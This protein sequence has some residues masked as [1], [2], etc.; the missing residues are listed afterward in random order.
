MYVLAPPGAMVK[1]LPEQIVPL[2][3]VTK[4]SAIT[5]TFETATVGDMQPNELVPVT[6]YDVVIVGDTIFVPLEY[7]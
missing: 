4:G 5:V 7:V 1:L 6:E 2:L 3:T